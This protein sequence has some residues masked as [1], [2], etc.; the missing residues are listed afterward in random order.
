MKDT[1]NKNGLSYMLLEHEDGYAI[2]GVSGTCT[3][4]FT[5]FEVV[6]IKCLFFHIVDSF[7]FLLIPRKKGKKGYQ[8]VF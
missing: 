8:R 1:F 5:H 7:I 2:Y 4:N 3:P 6:E